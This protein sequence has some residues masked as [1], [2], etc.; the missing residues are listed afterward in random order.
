MELY[1]C[2]R[3]KGMFWE[4]EMALHS[5]TN[6]GYYTY[7][8]SC[9]ATRAREW[10]QCNREHYNKNDRLRKKATRT[11]SPHILTAR[12]QAFR[13]YPDG[14]PCEV[15]G[16]TPAQRHHD[17]YSKPLEI[18][19]LCPVHHKEVASSRELITQS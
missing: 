19:W 8:R 9:N 10:R 1:G 5:N 12:M 3:C 13:A 4:D 7:C 17:D 15:C 2:A 18:R 6:G 14:Q 16:T 11:E